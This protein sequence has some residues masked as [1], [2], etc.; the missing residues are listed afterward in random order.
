MSKTQTGPISTQ[1]SNRFQIPFE[2]TLM[3][4]IKRDRLA[5]QPD[6][7]L[8]LTIG[9]L[10]LPSLSSSPKVVLSKTYHCRACCSRD[11]CN[12]LNPADLRNGRTM[13]DPHTREHAHG[14]FPLYD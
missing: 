7:G 10:L 9:C 3:L 2:A 4:T 13:S 6:N 1:A 12:W 11:D 8:I 14:A 5:N